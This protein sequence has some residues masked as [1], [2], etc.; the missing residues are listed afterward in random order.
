MGILSEKQNT[1]GAYLVV[2][3]LG[4]FADKIVVFFEVVERLFAITNSFY[5][6]CDSR[7]INVGNLRSIDSGVFIITLAL[8][9]HQLDA[10]V[11][12]EFPTL[13]AAT[14]KRLVSLIG[15][16]CLACRHVNKQKSVFFTVLVDARQILKLDGDGRHTKIERHAEDFVEFFGGTVNALDFALSVGNANSQHAAISVSHSHDWHCQRLGCNL[17]ALAVKSLP[18]LDRKSVV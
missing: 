15:V 4:I 18:L 1:G 3:C 8:V 6:L 2:A 17:N 11:E 9:V 16:K 13:V 5:E 14:H 12:R 10:L 7:H